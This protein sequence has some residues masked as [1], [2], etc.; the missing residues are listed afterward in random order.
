MPKFSQT[1]VLPYQPQE[2]FNLVLDVKSYPKFLPW[3]KLATIISQNE[4]QIIA[5]LTIQAKSFSSKYQSR[6]T[7]KIIN[8][9]DY[10][11]KVE[12]ISG[13]FKYLK[14]LWQFSQEGNNTKIEFFIEFEMKFSIINK[15]VEIFFADATKKMIKAFENR[16]S[17][18]LKKT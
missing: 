11:I 8:D 14:N 1:K 17:T 2:L 7:T 18:T 3:C 4:E 13:P 9:H 15:L 12:A 10:N 16:A 6:I 5:E